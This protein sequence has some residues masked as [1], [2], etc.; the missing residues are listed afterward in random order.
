[1]NITKDIYPTSNLYNYTSAANSTDEA[2]NYTNIDTVTAEDI[3]EK[4]KE[5]GAVTVELDECEFRSKTDT[6]LPGLHVNISP[7]IL[8]K[9][10]D[11]PV[12]RE[13]QYALIQHN[14]RVIA[15]P[16]VL[17]AEYAKGIGPE[18]IGFNSHSMRLD[19]KNEGYNKWTVS[20]FTGDDDVKVS[21]PS[22]ETEKSLLSKTQQ[23]K[24]CK[25]FDVSLSQI[26]ARRYAER[27]AE[28]GNIFAMQN[29]QVDLFEKVSNAYDKNVYGSDDVE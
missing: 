5:L 1:M 6:R 29:N 9:M 11:D 25:S 24:S 15:D 19:L 22:D 14:L 18:V 28:R 17:A 16:R 3:V 7:S 4:I 12:Y 20:R 23:E 21:E 13:S 8:K 27:F 10:I 26:F 2:T